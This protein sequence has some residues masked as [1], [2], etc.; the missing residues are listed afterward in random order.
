MTLET[1]EL[2]IRYGDRIAVR[3]TSLSLAPGEL[4]ALVGPNGAGKSSLLKGLTGVVATSGTVRWRGQPLAAL[5]RHH[6][7][8]SIAYLPQSPA[9]HWPLPARDLVALG[10]LPHRAYGVR[11][12]SADEIAVANAMA[13]TATT[14]FA[15]RNVDRLSV[16]ERARVL[17]ARALAVEAPVLLVDEPV[18]M[19]DPYHQLQ[20]MTTLR[21]YARGG[22]ATAEGGRAPA[23]V[24]AVLHDLT[25]AARFCSRV[26]LMSDGAVVGDAVPRLALTAEALQQHYGVEP[27][28]TTHEGEPV[29]V[30]WRALGD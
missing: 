26:L 3:P 10:R 23:L 6:R 12:N 30:P 20:I 17:L 4:V 19:L 2:A 16:G 13:S 21:N 7:A 24:M 1:H 15:A 28:L 8:R 18:A 25:L 9:V 22:R 29:I 14:P 27:L 5:D 11:S